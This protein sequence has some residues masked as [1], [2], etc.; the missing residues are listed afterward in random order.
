MIIV[1]EKCHAINFYDRFIWTCPEC[2]N[3]FR[4]EKEEKESSISEDIS[5]INTYSKTI[6][7]NS[8]ISDKD[9]INIEEDS[10]KTNTSKKR[11]TML[12]K[13]PM[14]LGILI[15]LNSLF[16]ILLAREENGIKITAKAVNKLSQTIGQNVTLEKERCTTNK[17]I[18][19]KSAY[20]EMRQI[21]SNEMNS[22]KETFLMK[23]FKTTIIPNNNRYTVA[24][25][26]NDKPKLSIL[27]NQ[28]A[29]ILYFSISLFTT[30]RV[31]L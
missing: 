7:N 23:C 6:T 1:C 29:P 2:G 18:S 12:P 16:L 4:D 30:L 21:L 24:L 5:E 31:L 20:S 14:V 15:F 26:S 8:L 22:L 13:K 10:S 9:N 28:W 3:K 19:I 17:K 11:N 27:F 25:I